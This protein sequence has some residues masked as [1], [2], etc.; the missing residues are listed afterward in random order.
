MTRRVVWVA[1]AFA[2]GA[3]VGCGDDDNP[4]I[5]GEVCGNGILESGEECDDGNT[6]DG[7]GCSASCTIED[8]AGESPEPTKPECGNGIVEKGESCDDPDDPGCTDDCTWVCTK[9]DD[10][11]DSN[12]C[13]GEEVCD[14]STH[15]CQPAEESAADETVC[16]DGLICLD[17]VCTPLC[18]S[19]EDCGA[20]TTCGG[21]PECIAGRCVATPAE[22]GLDCRQLSGV[23]GLCREAVCVGFECGDGFCSGNETAGTCADDCDALCG[24]G[25]C[26]HDETPATCA[27]D[28]AAVCGD[29]F[30]THNETVATCASDCDSLCGDGVCYEGET[31]DTCEMDC[32]AS[33]GDGFCTHNE[34]AAS[35]EEDCAALCGDGLC[36]HSENA[37]TCAADCPASCGDGICSPDAGETPENCQVDCPSQC[38]DGLC[39]AGETVDSCYDDCGS[40]GDGV[41]SAS[42][43]EDAST[44]YDDCGSCGDGICSASGGEDASTC[45][46]DCGFCGDDICG[47]DEDSATCSEDCGVAARSCIAHYQ[48]T[49]VKLHIEGT[50]LGMGDGVYDLP[51]GKMVL[52]YDADAQ[53]APIDGANVDILYY[54]LRNAF[55]VSG[56]TF[57][58][59]V[60]TV[61]NAFAP[62]CSGELNPGTLSAPDTCNYDNNT[63]ALATGT[64]AQASS[65]VVWATCNAAPEFSTGGA[66]GYTDAHVSSGPGCLNGYRSVGN[67]NCSG[68]NCSAGGLTKGDNPQ[69]ATWNQPLHAMTLSPQGTTLNFAKTRIP[70]A[71]PSKTFVVFAGTRTSVTCE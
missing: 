32:P 66:G 2:F 27:S 24:D 40:C 55:T 41:C 71:Q 11:S 52:R 51:N 57:K 34:D 64:Y 35:C 39:T 29:G 48:L 47:D 23:A 59:T 54:Y 50:T 30:C 69:N 1:A 16:G 67:V 61:V 5:Q 8:D 4:V 18:V 37:D 22:D 28:C 45:N 36:T 33:C 38:G 17:G 13:N 26:S 49:G 31:A 10:C 62:T 7:D 56:G 6:L 21:V 58:P 20:G 12:V 9:N 43:G 3:L 63:D 60:D 25:V 53:D 44:C 70:N 15:T 65:S 42:G 14:L 19:D 68:S 46:E